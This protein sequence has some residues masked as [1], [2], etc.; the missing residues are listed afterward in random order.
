MAKIR[1]QAHGEGG[2]KHAPTFS[3]AS[4]AD[5]LTK[6][7]SAEKLTMTMHTTHGGSVDKRS[8]MLLEEAKKPTD[9]ELMRRLK[10]QIFSLYQLV[11]GVKSPTDEGFYD[12]SNK[13]DLVSQMAFIQKSLESYE[14]QR[15][16][17]ISRYYK[18]K[19]TGDENEA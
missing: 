10:S 9:A 12:D 11:K 14:E 19:G 15:T 13:V 18:Y 6:S 1:G 5:S 17:I 3:L 2:K 7:Q 16:Y 8:G 4:I